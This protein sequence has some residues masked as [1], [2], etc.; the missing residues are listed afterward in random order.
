MKIL[1]SFVTC[2]AAAERH[3]AE[4]EKHQEIFPNADADVKPPP[5]LQNT[6][7]GTRD[8]SH[9]N[10]KHSLCSLPTIMQLY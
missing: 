8:P 3:S 6:F 2:S 7:S 9:H 4:K 10:N 1:S 5:H